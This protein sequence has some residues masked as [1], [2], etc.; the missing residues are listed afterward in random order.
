MENSNWLLKSVNIYEN[1]QKKGTYNGKVTFNNGVEM[2][3]SMTLDHEKCRKMIEILR[4]E[5]HESAVNLGQ[6]MLDS[7]TPAQEVKQLENN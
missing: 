1:W 2:E 4:D 5:I 3:I 6:R 7:L